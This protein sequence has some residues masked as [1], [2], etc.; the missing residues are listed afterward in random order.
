[1]RKPEEIVPEVLEQFYEAQLKAAFLGLLIFCKK[2]LE[3]LQDWVNTWI[4]SELKE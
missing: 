2:D 1:M 4:W 3:E